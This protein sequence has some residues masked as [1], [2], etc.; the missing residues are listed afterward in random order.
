MAWNTPHTSRF[1]RVDPAKGRFQV[2]RSAFT[3]PAVFAEERERILRKSWIFLGHESEIPKNNDYLT[4]RILDRNLIFSRD[5]AGE[6]HAFF[7]SCPHRGA[8]ICR[9]ATGNKKNFTCPYHG[10]TLAN[11][12]KLVDQSC[13]YGYAEDFADDRTLDLVEVP[14]I[15]Q[16]SGFWFLNFDA[17]AVSLDEYLGDAADRIDM[18]AQHSAAGLECINGGQE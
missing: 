12:G 16:R 14:R 5:R 11:S 10:W 2:N 9:D 3:D 4:R 17:N 7:N 1:L 6:V 13:K 15:A 18:I 8:T